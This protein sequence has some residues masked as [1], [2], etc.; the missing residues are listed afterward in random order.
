MLLSVNDQPP[1]RVEMPFA[2]DEGVDYPCARTGAALPPSCDVGDISPGD[3]VTVNV[4][5]ANGNVTLMQ[6]RFCRFTYED[7]LPA[8]DAGGNAVRAAGNGNGTQTC[9][10]RDVNALR[11]TCRG[12]RP[13]AP[14]TTYA[15]LQS[16]RLEQAV[17]PGRAALA[18]SAPSAGQF[19]LAL[20]RVTDAGVAYSCADSGASSCRLA[21][22]APGERIACAVVDP[23]K[24]SAPGAALL[25][26]SACRPP[27]DD[28]RT[29]PVDCQSR[30]V[31]LTLG[32]DGCAA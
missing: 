27:L 22:L 6:P 8:S 14:P 28:L 11:L 25:Q 5:E 12:C 7:L 17:K 3:I 19:L 1:L 18:C 30:A 23:S 21:R 2:T 29:R 10:S 24:V 31:R 16:I 20:P 26:A 32:C 9:S 15:T 4:L 13:A